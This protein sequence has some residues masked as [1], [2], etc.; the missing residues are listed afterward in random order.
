MLLSINEPFL[1]FD[2]MQDGHHLFQ[3]VKIVDFTIAEGG[4]C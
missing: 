2:V 1:K 4:V 3:D